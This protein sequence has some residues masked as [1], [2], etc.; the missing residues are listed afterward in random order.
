MRSLAFVLLVST[1]ALSSAQQPIS[2][3][4]FNNS[5]APTVNVTGKATDLDYRTGNGSS[6]SLGSPNFVLDSVNGTVKPVAE[7][8]APDFFRANHGMSA[9]GG[10]VY[11]N[12]YTMVFDVKITTTGNWVSFFN[13]NADVAND[14]EAFI[15]TD[16]K[17]GISGV[18]DGFFP[19]NTW[20]RV[21]ISVDCV[22]RLIAIYVNGRLQ[23]QVTISGVDGRW[24]AYCWDDPDMGI[25]HIDVFGDNDGDNGS[26]YISGLAFYD[27]VLRPGEVAKLGIAGN[28]FGPKTAPVGGSIR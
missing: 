19:R 18:Y 20:N 2:V 1:C 4:N 14:G 11:V 27:K 9:N 23:N 24:A 6:I 28:P 7:F 17:V 10:G 22:N 26:G 12:Q 15:R 16:D 13:T 25:D 21:A 5:L 8:W 3:Y